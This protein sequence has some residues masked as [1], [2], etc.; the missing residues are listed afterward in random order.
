MKLRKHSPVP[1]LR[2]D[3][4]LDTESAPLIVR[5]VMDQ[6]D[7][8]L[9]VHRGRVRHA[10]PLAMW[11]LEMSLAMLCVVIEA[12]EYIAECQWG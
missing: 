8:T 1:L 4:R 6:G 9:I 5:V 2:L 3:E 12:R 10:S 7:A 11:A